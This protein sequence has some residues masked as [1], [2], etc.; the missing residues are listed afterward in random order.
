MAAPSEIYKFTPMEYDYDDAGGLFYTFKQS[1]DAY[2][3]AA[4]N[5][6]SG[7]TKDLVS[8][9]EMEMRFKYLRT[10]N[11]RYTAFIL[12]KLFY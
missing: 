7:E 6:A 1:G 9:R 2:K 3:L 10:G 11:M 5:V 4:I 8:L 12:S